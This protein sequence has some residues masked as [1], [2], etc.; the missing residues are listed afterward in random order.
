MRILVVKLTSM[1]DAIHVLPALSDLA[2]HHPDAKVDWMIEQS[3]AEIPNWH[4]LVDRISFTGG[5]ESAGHIVRNAAENFAEVS[6]ELGGKSP[7]IIFDDVD[8]DN[9]TNGVL[10][11]IFSASGQSCVAG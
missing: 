3:F 7:M 1:G 5:L 8:L 4:P 11:S 9:A 2:E 6:L 10:L